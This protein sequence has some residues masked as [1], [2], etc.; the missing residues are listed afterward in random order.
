MS[1]GIYLLVL[2]CLSQVNTTILPITNSARPTYLPT[3]R[4]FRTEQPQPGRF[5]VNLIRARCVLADQT[6]YIPLCTGPRP[7]R[8]PNG[9]NAFYPSFICS[10]S[11]ACDKRFH[12]LFNPC[13]QCPL[14]NIHFASS[15]E[16]DENKR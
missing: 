6:E 15:C 3:V 13:Q 9:T 5:Q 8:R 7:P 2:N 12:F 11:V 14:C 4:I 1:Y 10:H 16:D